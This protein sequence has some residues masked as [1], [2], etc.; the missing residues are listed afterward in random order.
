MDHVSTVFAALSDPLR[1]RALA[2]LVRQ[3]EL[4]VCE[5]THALA[6][7]QPKASKHLATLRDAGLLRVRRDARWVLYAVADDLAPWARRAVAAAAD[8]LEGD[9]A[10]RG[11]LERLAAMPGRPSRTRAA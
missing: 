8:G 4:C 1:L 2:L 7:A 9:A 11:D 6:I 5:V 3:G 10:H